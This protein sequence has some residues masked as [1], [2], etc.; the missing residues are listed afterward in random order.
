[1]LLGAIWLTAY[2]ISSFACIWRTS[3]IERRLNQWHVSKIGPL[4]IAETV[5]LLAN[6][7][8]LHGEQTSSGL[9]MSRFKPPLQ[10][11]E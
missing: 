10:F 6:V 2:C 9:Q 3:G 8:I 4:A 1:M 7:D 11:I 5:G